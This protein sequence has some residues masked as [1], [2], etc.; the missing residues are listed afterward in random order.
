MGAPTKLH[1]CSLHCLWTKR[2]AAQKNSKP[3]ETQWDFRCL[4]SFTKLNQ[5][6]VC[7]VRA[8]CIVSI[9]SSVLPYFVSCNLFQFGSSVKVLQCCREGSS[10]AFFCVRIISHTG[11]MKRPFFSHTF[12]EMCAYLA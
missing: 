9:Q 4:I 3:T 10:Y 8:R 6:R 5:F 2:G 1:V 11:V 12:K 7:M